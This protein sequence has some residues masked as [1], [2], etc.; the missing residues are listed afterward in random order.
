MP[1]FKRVIVPTSAVTSAV[2]NP[3]RSMQSLSPRVLRLLSICLK[4]QT[5]C[6]LGGMA[7]DK[8]QS[9]AVS[10]LNLWSHS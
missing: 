5:D 7:M 1:K 6:S 9:S 8:D 3:M 10:E 4:H 2:A